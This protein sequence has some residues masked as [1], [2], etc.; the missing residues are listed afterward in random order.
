LESGLKEKIVNA[1]RSGGGGDKGIKY[2][3][4]KTLGKL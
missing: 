3:F 4:F 1:V 2:A